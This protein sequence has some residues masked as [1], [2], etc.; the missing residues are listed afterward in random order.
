MTIERHFHDELQ[1]GDIVFIR[2]ANFLYRRVASATNGWT[3]HVG[4]LYRREKDDWVVVESA[5]PWSR[6]CTL[7][8]FLERSEGGRCSIKRVIRPLDETEQRKL[9]AQA[10]RRM[11][12][13]YHLGFD[14][15]SRLQ[16]C[17]KFVHEIYRDALGVEI[18]TVQTFRELLQRNP[19]SPLKF[20]KAWFLGRIPWDRRTLTPASQY[21][22]PLLRTV[23]DRPARAA[24]NAPSKLGG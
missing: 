14:F 9:K 5:V 11:G 18:G 17:S 4:I 15:D 2:V 21:E 23:Y 24:S 1:V 20:W 19:E 10:D 7:S 6:Y 12:K 8:R 13:L 3:S 22:S 16:F